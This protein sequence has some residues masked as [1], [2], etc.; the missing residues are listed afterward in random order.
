M[1]VRRGVVIVVVLTAVGL[2][3]A[4]IDL[5]TSGEASGAELVSASDDSCVNMEP[6]SNE[7]FINCS[8][9]PNG[10]WVEVSHHDG[11]V[12]YYYKTREPRDI[13]IGES[14][15]PRKYI[16]GPGGQQVPPGARRPHRGGN[17]ITPP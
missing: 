5:V 4:G 14:M 2:A 15:I 6:F 1:S 7:W 11:T 10:C 3:P 13:C 17:F 16:A 12:T 9:R 8:H